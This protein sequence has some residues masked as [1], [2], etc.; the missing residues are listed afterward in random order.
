MA[1][2]ADQ[3]QLPWLPEL[4][5]EGKQ[6]LDE[7]DATCEPTGSRTV[8]AKEARALESLEQAAEMLGQ[9]DT[10]SLSEDLEEMASADLKYL[11]VPAL[12]GALVLKQVWAGR[13]LQQ[14]QLAR[15]LFLDYLARCQYYRVA[16]LE[17]PQADEGAEEEGR[18]ASSGPAG[19]VA[20]AAR[21]R[22][23][24]GRRRQRK[25]LERRLEALQGAVDGGLADDESVREYY[26]LHL[27]RWV[28]IS[29]EEIEAIDQ[30]TRILR[31]RDACGETSR[32]HLPPPER[33]QVR[34][35]VLA[36]SRAQGAAVLGAGYPSQA[37]M[38][39]SDWYDQQRKYGALPDPATAPGT[40]APEED[41]KAVGQ[42]WEWDDW[43]D[44]RYGTRH[45]MG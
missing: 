10:F 22:A 40:P 45:H 24:V 14:L 13:R 12:R 30:E 17:L 38:T 21:R 8:Q 6:L 16:E 31:A 34:P 23:T 11:L 7:V 27:R 44:T 26:L 36:R 19:L 20:M 42:V 3:F 1:A 9:L 4:F 33:P 28:G 37:T 5:E 25:E 43:K 18:A 41:E 15:E 2:A 35:F 32:S 29:L 39:V